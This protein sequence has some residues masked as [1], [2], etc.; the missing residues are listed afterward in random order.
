MT[1]YL[2][3]RILQM[4][5]VVFLSTVV[6]FLILNTVPGGPLDGL[7]FRGTSSRDQVSQEDI[8]RLERQYDLDLPIWQRYTRWLIGYPKVPDHDN[9]KRGV[10]RLDFGESWAI[11]KNT[12]V[13]ELIKSRLPNTLLL[14]LTATI[15]SLVVAIP[16]GVYSAVRQYSAFDY[17]VTSF[18]FFGQSMPVFW[19]GLLMVIL[20]AHKFREWGLPYLPTGGLYNERNVTHT[21][22]ERIRYLVMPATV[23][24][25]LS[26]ATWSRFTRA[27]MLEVIRQ[28]Y[29]RTARAKGVKERVV[30]IKHALRNALIPLIT[31]VVLQLPNI[32]SGAIITETVFT[33][34]GTGRLYF[35]ALGRAD[36]PVA[37][38]F[39]FITAILY[40][41]ATLI[42][43]VAYVI[44]DP[45]IR[46][47]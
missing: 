13:L 40:V 2:I 9:T 28:D 14:M 22:V 4:T 37:M 46:F 16:V 23:L 44:V 10:L 34:P 35:D 6:I 26:M 7:R 11:S 3:R 29:I 43:D 12:P 15:L 27:S 24:S 41:I 42:R 8:A 36:W 25:L 1:A 21:I 33:W 45:R 19:F 39:L 18:S 20:F 30:I 5:I 32:F 31:L 47:D 38:A 17:A